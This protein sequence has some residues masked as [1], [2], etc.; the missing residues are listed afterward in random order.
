EVFVGCDGNVTLV[1]G[2][3]VVESF[4]RLA[5]PG[6]ILSLPGTPAPI[7]I[8]Q[9]LPGD[10]SIFEQLANGDY[11]RTMSDGTVYSFSAPHIQ[12][13]TGKIIS[14]KLLSVVDRYNNHTTYKY[15]PAGEHIERIIDPVTL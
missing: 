3:G 5:L 4:L 14:G 12:A 11:R 8:F 10:T 1:D 7:A 6:G 9:G 13:G 15:D 2:G